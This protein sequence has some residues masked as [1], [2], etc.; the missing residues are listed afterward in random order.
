M[1]AVRDL[2]MHVVNKHHEKPD[3]N[4]DLCKSHAELEGMSKDQLI[5]LVELLKRELGIAWHEVS[6]RETEGAL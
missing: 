4:C 5:G 3:F 2:E 6:I 1:A